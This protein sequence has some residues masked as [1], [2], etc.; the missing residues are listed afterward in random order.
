MSRA[1]AFLFLVACRSQQTQAVE[2]APLPSATATASA[3]VAQP[4]A[5]MTVIDGVHPVSLAVDATNVYWVDEDHDIR[6]APIAGGAASTIATGDS[7]SDIAVGTT[8]VYWIDDPGKSFVR[9][10]PIAGGQR[11]DVGSNPHLKLWSVVS[12][13]SHVY[14]ADYFEVHVAGLAA[15]DRPHSLACAEGMMH[16]AVGPTHVVCDGVLSKTIAAAPLSG[17]AARVLGPMEAQH[18]F[19]IDATDAYWTNSA[20]PTEIAR[21]SLAAGAARSTPVGATIQKPIAIADAHII[22]ARDDGAILSLP[23]D[24]GAFRVLVPPR[25]QAKVV[26]IVAKPAFVYVAYADAIMRIPTR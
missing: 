6:K 7:P 22:V 17:G 25:L 18:A 1:V 10:A 3:T 8:D 23:R 16:I 5:A 15:F 20:K 12:D 9:A 19:A 11:R 24:G 21:A 26:A 2:I 13:E 14:W 4:R